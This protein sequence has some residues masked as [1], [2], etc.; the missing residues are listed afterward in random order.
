[1]RR[2]RAH[3][4]PEFIDV[5]IGD[6]DPAGCRHHAQASHPQLAEGGVQTRQGHGLRVDVYKRQF[7]NKLWNASRFVLMHTAGQDLGL[8]A[9]APDTCSSALSFSFADRWIV[10]KLQRSEE[11]CIRDRI[12]CTAS[13]ASRQR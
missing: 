3:P 10:S 6:G 9:C 12:R 11:M 1:M 7:C 4:L 13:S 8:D 5:A 2:H